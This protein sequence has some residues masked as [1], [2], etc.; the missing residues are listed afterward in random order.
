[1]AKVTVYHIWGKTLTGRKVQTDVMQ[2]I[3]IGK[4]LRVGNTFCKVQDIAK[5]Q[6][7]EGKVRC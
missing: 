1:M 4:L 3:E 2:P 7:E 5:Y 6:L